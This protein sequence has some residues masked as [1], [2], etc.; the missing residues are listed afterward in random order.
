MSVGGTSRIAD[1]EARLVSIMPRDRFR[2][3]YDLW[4]DEQSGLLLR[5]DLLSPEGDRIEQYMFV[6]IDIGAN[7]S[8]AQL[9]A[10]TP[11][12]ELSWY[13]VSEK[14]KDDKNEVME[15]TVADLP[16]GFNLA[17]SI[18]RVS[19]MRGMPVEH[20]V[21]TDGLASVS[22]FIEEPGSSK[23]PMIEGASS[24]GAVSAFGR[25]VDGHQITVV[26]EVPEATVR[27]IGMSVRHL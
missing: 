27:M 8:D 13:G 24:M 14:Q 19:P 25:N 20:H 17:T 6:E 26:G 1:R 12:E 16:G 2:Y 9:T 22:I 21:Y 5:A 4:A 15:W 10:V 11:K 3:G 7:V 23:G 18:K